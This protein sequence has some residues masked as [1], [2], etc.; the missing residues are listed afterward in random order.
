MNYC[1]GSA[2]AQHLNRCIDLFVHSTQE[3]DQKCP[4][5]MNLLSLHS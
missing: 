2:E 1:P 5:D 4:I 3:E